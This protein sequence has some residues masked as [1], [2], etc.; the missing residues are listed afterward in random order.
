MYFHISKMI[1]LPIKI[2]LFNSYL[3]FINYFC[4]YRQ[5]CLPFKKTCV[6]IG[7]S[8]DQ[9]LVVYFG[10]IFQS[11]VLIKSLHSAVHKPA[12]ESSFIRAT[13]EFG[14]NATKPPQ[15]K[16]Q[17]EIDDSAYANLFG[18]QNSIREEA[19][20]KFLSLPRSG[21][22]LSTAPNPALG[23]HPS[24]IEFCVPLKNRLGVKL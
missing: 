5:A 12:E 14:K 22:W 6:G 3:F 4:R 7:W 2:Y 20:F 1:F 24:H 17:E 16:T 9:V 15:R 8:A 19:R 21:A 18:E 10:S 23:L 13:E 11:A